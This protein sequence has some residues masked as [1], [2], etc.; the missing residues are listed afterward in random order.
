V[1]HVVEMIEK[2]QAESEE[3][4][5][6]PSRDMD[7]LNYVLQSKEH[8]GRTC[9]YRNRPWKHALKS[10]ANSYGKKR[11]HDELFEDKIQEEVQIILQAEREK[12]HESFQGHIQA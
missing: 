5:F 2:T 6:V 10:T 9:G 8:P 3:D 12:M 7:D 4:K 11:K 1:K